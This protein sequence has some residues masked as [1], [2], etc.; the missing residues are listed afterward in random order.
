[1]G[2]SKGT[3]PEPLARFCARLRRLQEASGLEKKA[4]AG[5]VHV[6]PQSLSDL[7]NGNIRKLP[8]WER[9]QAIVDADPNRGVLLEQIKRADGLNMQYERYA[10]SVR[11]ASQS[12]NIVAA[13]NGDKSVND[14]L[15]AIADDVDKALAGTGK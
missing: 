2:P 13:I 14:A 11:W 12:Q 9:V 4:L 3:A 8:Q 1:M 10:Q 6:S 15:A 5:A 7:L